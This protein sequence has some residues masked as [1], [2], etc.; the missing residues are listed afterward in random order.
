[1]ASR[2]GPSRPRQGGNK[3]RAR[4]EAQAPGLPTLSDVAQKAGVSS[5]TVSRFLNS[6][7]IV[8]DA[9]SERIR[10][11]IAATN[12]VPNLAAGALASNKSRLV[13]AFVPSISQ[14]IFSSTIQSMIDE[15]SRNGY[16]VVVGLVGNHN[17][18]LEAGL[19]SVLGR[20]PDGLI[21]T[22]TITAP[23]LRQRIL[24]ARIPTIETWDLPADP[25]DMAVGFSHEAVGRELA[26]FALARGYR[27]PFL[28]QG[29][30]SRTLMRR[31][32][33]SRT[34]VER[35]LA[36]PNYETMDYPSS[37]GQ[38]RIA[39]ANCLDSGSKPDLVV[40]SSDWT[41]HGVLAEAT[42]RGLRIPDDLG[43]IGFGDLD[44]AADLI[45]PLTTVYIDGAMIGREAANFLL[46]R[47]GNKAPS[48]RVVDIGFKII[49]RQT[50]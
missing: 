48:T 38:G 5:A 10:K 49:E 45:P 46:K 19:N 3:A 27:R 20:R 34:F 50:A 29:P 42:M 4:D 32:G 31:H 22:G 2:A 26:D 15:L 30:G 8:A 14:S 39:L 47:A 23:T 16:H 1:M 24:A 11:A 17:E 35:G 40:C 25:L 18:H 43:V 28:I 7:G 6:P 33:F 12:Y 41:A 36:E 9:T 21:L 44:F 37:F 13:A